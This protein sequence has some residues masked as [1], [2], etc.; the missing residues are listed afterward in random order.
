MAQNTPPPMPQGPPHAMAAAHMTAPQQMQQF[1]PPAQQAPHPP[2]PA[3]QLG[4]QVGGGNAG[5]GRVL[6]SEWTKIR[7]VRSTMWTLAVIV[8]LIVG[9]GILL[10]GTVNPKPKDD[11]VSIALI[12]VII[13]Q[14]AAATLGVLTISAEYTTGMIRTTLTAYPR[15]IQ[16]LAAKGVVFAGLMFVV[17]LVTIGL[18]AVLGRAMLTS[19]IGEPEIGAHLLRS[20]LGGSLYLAVIG[21]F[22]LG[23]GVLIRHSAGAITALMGAILLPMIIGPFLPHSVGSKVMEYSPMFALARLIG[24]SD[25]GSGPGPWPSLLLIACYAAIALIAGGIRLRSR[26]V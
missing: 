3:A 4:G 5:F 17:G 11:Y 16:V 14:L 15:R 7:T 10:A 20:V 25:K 13:A 18:T 24:E 8:L 21:L 12:G 2:V 1:P 23:L 6:L 9:L 19:R 22:G 26:D